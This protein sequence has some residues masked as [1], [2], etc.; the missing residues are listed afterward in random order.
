M[1]GWPMKEGRRWKGSDL[2]GSK[3]EAQ[4]TFRANTSQFNAGLKQMESKLKTYRSELKLNAAQMKSTGESLEG[5][6]NKQSILKNELTASREK[7]VLLNQ[8]LEEAKRI[9]GENATET[10][11]Y[12]RELARA[13]TQQIAIQSEIAETN[14][15]IK[16]QEKANSSLSQSI[17][18]SSSEIEKLDRELELN[19][20]KLQGASDKT[21]LLK[22]RQTLLGNQSQSSA[23][24]VKALEKA[25]EE[26][27][28]E[29][30]ENSDAYSKLS[31]ELM[32]A[33]VQQAAIQ[34]EIKETTKELKEQKTSLQMAGDAI[35]SFGGKMEN[36]GQ[37]LRGVSTAAAG[38]LVAAGASAVTF[39]S[40]FA[41]VMKTT[42]EVYDANGKCIYSYQQL[43]DGI[44]SMAKEIPAST[45]EISAVAESAGQL[46]IKTQDILGFT[47]VM[48]DMGQ[49]TN[50][51]SEEAAT[52]IAKFS[53]ITGLSAD[54]TMS[55]KEK[56]SR[57]GSVI[58]DLGNN[59][60]T[61]EADIV[62]MA[63]N[64]A[65]A[66]T[67][68]G[69]TESDILALAASL[70]SV[71][72]E[73]EA[74]G[75]AFSKT[76]I[77]MQLA[78]ETNSDSLKEWASVAGMSADEFSKK[79]K[80]DAT[81]ALQAFIEGLS[82][83]GGESESA[84]KILDDMG[85][86]ET[87]LRDALLRSANASDVFTSAIQTGR[88]A[89]QENNALQEE[90]NKRYETTAS[91]LKIMKNHIQDAGITLGSVFLPVLAEAARKISELADKLAG[92]DKGTQQVIVGVF[93]FVAVLSPLLIGIGKIS[94]GISTI[95]GMGTKLSGMFTGMGA[96]AQAGGTAAA[97][98]MSAPILPILGII[99]AITATIGIIAFLWVK[100]EDFRNFFTRMWEGFKDVI[101]GFLDKINFGDKID[102]IKE[103]F[104]GLGEK[105]KGLSDY[106]KAV[107]T[108]LAVSLV[109]F[110]TMAAGAF[111]AILSAIEPIITV[112]GGL[113]DVV[114]GIGQIVVGVFTGDLEKAKGGL[115]TFVSG[116]S[117]TFG[118]LWGIVSG[119]LGG[120][121]EGIAGF[122][123]SLIEVTGISEFVEGVKGKFEEISLKVSN[124]FTTIGNVIQVALM[125]IGEIISAGFQII[126]LPFMFIW[127]NCKEIVMGAWE[128]ISQKISEKLNLISNTIGSIF[129]VISGIAST[130]WN[131]IKNTI[132]S[133]WDAIQNKVSLA[134]TTVK[135]VINTGFELAKTY[136]VNPLQQAKEKVSSI[137]DNIKKSITDKINAAKD[138]VK[139]AID[140]IKGFFDFKWS[141][142]DLKLPHPKVTGK[143]S[144]N[145]PSVPHFSLEWYKKGAIFTRPTIFNTRSGM[146]G[147]G[148]AG[149]E[150]VLPIEKLSGYVE[151]GVNNSMRRILQEQEMKEIDYDKLAYACSKIHIVNKIGEREFQRLVMEVM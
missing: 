77:N 99:A 140:K 50:L 151:N 12:E 92:M 19:A 137:F 93:A 145:P 79:F 83:C 78:V 52:A 25:L 36:A 34:N 116:I 123:S 88:T 134:T 6:K 84:I 76:L 35:G 40:A 129:S 80:E 121:V 71:G 95:I 114:A 59:Y 45:T 149:A 27:E 28:R 135:N 148:E 20:T 31:A 37:K 133:V 106:F 15:K 113:I 47:R 117:E 67:Q 30:G 62:N 124:V 26:C 70:S 44:R 46:G 73:A 18:K 3:R 96:T 23:D 127:E 132:S 147:V 51:A 85:I 128:S 75:T 17:E 66:G 16:E 90:A 86:K 57:L 1:I 81:G 4:V 143:F 138:A 60:A 142:P 53:N 126:T 119:V 8:K 32:E 72:L 103:K 5:L 107:G 10:Q 150:A 63:Q 97:V 139:S 130:I 68:I 22:E 125:T 13:R 48:I 24:K 69:M 11:T 118:G 49:S 101:D 91:Q 100:C 41:G 131:G 136:I 43:E 89:W 65:S 82:K 146:K 33:K 110:L 61:T 122:F 9:F 115:D 120:F 39:E 105:L 144:L 58:V 14:T 112:L 98:G 64:L 87:R 94:T 111:N 141:L 56:Y 109:P 38:T 104:S 42:D 102:G 54:E 55:A 21:T 74:G 29:A 7:I 2:L 108:V